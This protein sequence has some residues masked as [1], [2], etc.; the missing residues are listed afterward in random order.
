MKAEEIQKA[1]ED[2]K[3]KYCGNGMVLESVF[4]SDFDALLEKIIPTDEEIL[5]AEKEFAWAFGS[6]GLFR[7]GCKWVRNRVT[8]KQ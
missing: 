6:A 1:K 5:V 2:F 7:D 4:T 8:G 3:E